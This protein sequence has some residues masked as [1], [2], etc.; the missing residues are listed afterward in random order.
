MREYGVPDLYFDG[1]LVDVDVPGAELYSQSGLVI[2]FESSFCEPEKEAGLAY[3]LIKG[4]CTG[5][6]DDDEFEHKI[7]VVGHVGL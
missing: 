4:C 6:S 1:E 5:I 7:V 2:C 3:A